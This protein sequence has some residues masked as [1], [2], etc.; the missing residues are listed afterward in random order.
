[1]MV[2]PDTGGPY[3]PCH[4]W[5]AAVVQNLA[6]KL[7]PDVVITSD[8]P[9]LATMAHPAGG[10]AAQADIGAGMAA[11]WKQ[12]EQAGISVVAIKE[13]PSMGLN[14]PDCVSKNPS[15]RSKCTVPTARAIPEDMPIKYAAKAAA[16]QVPVIDMNS[17]ICKPTKCPPVVG[18]VLVYQD[19]H[20]LTSTYALTTAPYLE[21]RLLAVSKPL[22]QG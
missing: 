9:G 6:T 3:T 12:L 11:Y 5:G 2:T 22:A 4:A 13:S 17:L 20:H 14:V 21:K 1:M 7:K 19:D 10:T 18:N 15:E 16:G 8:L